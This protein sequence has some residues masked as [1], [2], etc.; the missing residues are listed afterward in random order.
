MDEYLYEFVSLMRGAITMAPLVENYV[1][2]YV[3]FNMNNY[4]QLPREEEQ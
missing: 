2:Q 4:I 3:A 1:E